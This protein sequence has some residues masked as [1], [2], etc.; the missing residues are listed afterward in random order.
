MDGGDELYTIE[1]HFG[2]GVSQKKSG[3]APPPGEKI[4][5]RNKNQTEMGAVFTVK[6]PERAGETKAEK[7][8]MIPPQE[9][10]AREAKRQEFLRLRD[11]IFNK[12]R[13]PVNN[14]FVRQARQYA[15]EAPEHANPVSFFCYW[16][17]YDVMTKPQLDWYFY[18]RK[19]ARNGNYPPITQSYLYVYIYEIINGVG[20]RGGEDGF[21]QLCA[22]WGAYRKPYG[23]LDRNLA[24]WV[25][26]Y[27]AI[28]FPEGVPDH[29]LAKV[30]DS[31]IFKL[32]P[33]S[34]IAESLFRAGENG[35]LAGD[36]LNIIVKYSSYN[37]EK[38]K[39]YK[40]NDPSFIRSYLAGACICLNDT[41]I[42]KTGKGIFATFAPPQPHRRMPYSNAIYQGDVKNVPCPWQG[43]AVNRRL[44]DFL[45]A[46]L[47]AAENALRRLTGYRG[48]LKSDLAPEYAVLAEKY[49]TEREKR[50]I[51]E[52]RAREFTKIDKTKVKEIIVNADI[53]REKLLSGAEAEET[54]PFGVDLTP[55]AQKPAPMAAASPAPPAKPETPGGAGPG[56]AYGEFLASLS[57]AQGDIL[58]YLKENGGT[59]SL[60]GLEQRFQACFPRTEIDGM[61]EKAIDFLGDILIIEEGEMLEIQDI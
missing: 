26:D 48:K 52:S 46:Y 4:P 28:H 31:E 55:P 1:I 50:E 32:L 47:K 58:A 60:S 14:S 36:L 7:I 61:N 27:I 11:A 24:A 9:K 10:A 2:G 34:V 45:G 40:Q 17:T 12:N 35:P 41:L 49:V 29:V 6:T 25:S 43:F 22:L 21:I 19:L 53:I 59:A 16:P 42:K 23:A 38:S 37:P 57:Q 5:A 3:A 39:F 56:G 33:E 15:D 30:T 44:K 8:P 51:A 13:G 18:W 20:V 54:S